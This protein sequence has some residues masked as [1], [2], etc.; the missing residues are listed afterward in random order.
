MRVETGDSGALL[1]AADVVAR[2]VDGSL[3]ST[4]RCVLGVPYLRPLLHPESEITV[5]DRE[6][7]RGDVVCLLGGGSTLVWRRVLHIDDEGLVLRADLAPASERWRGPIVGCVVLRGVGRHLATRFPEAWAQGVWR[8]AFELSKLRAALPHVARS[9]ARRARALPRVEVRK[10]Q[11]HELP[12]LPRLGAYGRGLLPRGG[13]LPAGTHILGAFADA[14]TLVGCGGLST[15]R[16]PAWTSNLFVLP[17]WRAMGIARGIA[18]ERLRVAAAEG[19]SEVRTSIR[20]RNLASVRLHEALGFR[21][22]DEAREPNN[23]PE[24][25]IWSVKLRE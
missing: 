4:W 21:L 1:D 8:A 13:K 14:S 24:F 10:L 12:L 17:E 11:E 16:D 18:L 7:R 6:P 3:P 2:Y 22:V 25:Q 19:A 15:A 9:T 5:V 20:A 23:F